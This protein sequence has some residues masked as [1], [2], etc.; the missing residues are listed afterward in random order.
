MFSHK[1][2]KHANKNNKNIQTHCENSVIQIRGK[3]FGLVS[4]NLM[5]DM[6]LKQ[7]IFNS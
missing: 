4:D 2:G 3:Q 1:E 5:A 7:N 6:K